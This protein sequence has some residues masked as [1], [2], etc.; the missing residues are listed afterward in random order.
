M[1]SII[2]DGLVRGRGNRAIL[3][4]SNSRFV[5]DWPR[6]IITV[7]VSVSLSTETLQC[8]EKRDLQALG[9]HDRVRSV[10]NA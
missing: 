3:H 9:G 10:I 8:G 2:L 7:H 1:V 6:P 4:A 5:R